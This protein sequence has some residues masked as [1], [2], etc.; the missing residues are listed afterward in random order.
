MKIIGIFLQ[1]EFP[2]MEML[3]YHY[4]NSTHENWIEIARRYYHG[5]KL[6][7][8]YLA[9]LIVPTIDFGRVYSRENLTAEPRYEPDVSTPI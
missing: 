6:D 2:V 3:E 7:R 8:D 1:G 9:I 5:H 4:D